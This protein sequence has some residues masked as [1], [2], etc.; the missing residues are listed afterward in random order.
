MPK[1]VLKRVSEITQ[2]PALGTLRLIVRKMLYVRYVGLC[3]QS[4]HKL[5]STWQEKINIPNHSESHC[6]CLCNR[7]ISTSGNT[8]HEKI[9]LF[10]VQNIVILELSW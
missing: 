9:D 4:L 10:E 3:L 5:M 2:S 7:T 1:G 8:C 6:R